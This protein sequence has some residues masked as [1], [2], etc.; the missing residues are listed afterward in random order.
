MGARGVDA[1]FVRIGAHNSPADQTTGVSS[2]G[3]PGLCSDGC[4]AC[5]ASDELVLTKAVSQA[6]SA[7]RQMRWWMT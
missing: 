1:C 6:E 7:V 4:W 2:A 3:Y 5:G